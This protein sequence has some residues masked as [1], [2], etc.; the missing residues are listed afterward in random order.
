MRNDA[1]DVIDAET[2]LFER[3]L[4]CAQHGDDRLFVNFFAGHVDGCQVKIDIVSRDWAARTTA[5]HEENVAELTVATDMG[6][7]DPVAAV[8]AMTKDGRTRPVAEKHAAVA[9]CPIGDRGQFLRANHKDGVVSVR[10]DKLLAD[11]ESEN[12]TGA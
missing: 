11:L 5:R 10:S 2:R 6:A 8:P 4:G 1:G 9:I 3:L 12:E 7:D